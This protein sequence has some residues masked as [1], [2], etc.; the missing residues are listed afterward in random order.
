VQTAVDYL[1]ENRL[2]FGYLLIPLER[3]VLLAAF[4][5]LLPLLP[6]GVV[7]F[8][9]TQTAL[10]SEVPTSLEHCCTLLIRLFLPQ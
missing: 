8:H 5:Q 7:S 2:K 3:L 6:V 4:H 10:A 1:S 9:L